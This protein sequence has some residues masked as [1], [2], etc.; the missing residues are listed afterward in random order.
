MNFKEFLDLHEMP[1]T[2]FTKIGDWNPDAKR[3]YGFDRKDAALLSSARAVD[4]I[5]RKWSNSK[6][7]FDLIFLRDKNAYKHVELGEVSSEW[8]KENLKIDVNPNEDSITIIFTNNTGDERV[9]MTSWV[10]AHR[11]GHAI[12]RDKIFEEYFANAI[13]KDFME[14]LTQIFGHR[15]GSRFSDSYRADEGM[16]K[17]FAMAVGN[18]RSA[19]DRNLRNFGEFAYELVAQYITTGK[20]KFKPIPRYLIT[21]MHVAWGRPMTQGR[22]ANLDQDEIDEWNEI[23]DGHG[24]KYEYYLDSVFNGLDGKIFVM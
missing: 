11:L 23:L 8:V 13:R 4:K 1:I 3:K 6:Q 16:L 22:H 10:I 20:I 15:F 17:N 12:R 5:H 21:K 18:M 2:S 7:N 14:L 9:M 24:S 19:R